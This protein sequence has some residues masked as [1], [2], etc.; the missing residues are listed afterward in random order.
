HSLGEFSAYHAAE[1]LT[2][3]DAVRLVRRRG[4]LMYETGV[5][6]PGSMAAILGDLNRPIEEICA[7]VSADVATVVPA[8]YNTPGQVVISGENAA[9]EQAMVLCKEA[10]AKRAIL[11]KVSGAFHSSLMES[12]LSGLAE[13]LAASS[14]TDPHFAVYANV[15]AE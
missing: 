11:L 5:K 2:L 14:F 13:A 9:V 1:S 15:N 6:R 4:E 7:Q 12:A 10:G 3:E 8:N